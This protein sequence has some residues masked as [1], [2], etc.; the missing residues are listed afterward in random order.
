MF[1]PSAIDLLID[2]LAEKALAEIQ[3]MA[4]EALRAVDAALGIHPH[5][6]A[7]SIGQR[8]RWARARATKETP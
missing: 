2:R 3:R 4:A 7:R 5:F 6:T 8:R 1:E